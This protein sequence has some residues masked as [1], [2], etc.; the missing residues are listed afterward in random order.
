MSAQKNN[1][2]NKIQSDNI[3]DDTKFEDIEKDNDVIEEQ[4]PILDF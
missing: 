2:S 1:I 3:N 4:N